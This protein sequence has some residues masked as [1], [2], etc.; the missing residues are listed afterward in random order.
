MKKIIYF[1]LLLL[2]FSLLIPRINLKV[3]ADDITNTDILS[4]NNLIIKVKD[5]FY[6]DYS[7]RIELFSLIRPDWWVGKDQAKYFTKL[8]FI[9]TDPSL[10]G[11]K[12]SFWVGFICSG[13]DALEISLMGGTTPG[14]CYQ[15]YCGSLQISDDF[16]FVFPAQPTGNLTSPVRVTGGGWLDMTVYVPISWWSD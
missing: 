11:K 9:S 7:H 4:Q 3:N 5:P 10:P 13:D 2:T 12:K 15:H 6:P 8:T 16:N 1:I 14:T